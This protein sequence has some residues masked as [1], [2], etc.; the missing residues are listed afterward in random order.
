LNDDLREACLAALR[1]PRQ[2]CA[3][4]AEGHSWDASARAFIEN[5]ADIRSIP[6]EPDA[7]RFATEEAHLVG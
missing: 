7:M 5:M 2:E 6:L 3:K 1:I 4:F